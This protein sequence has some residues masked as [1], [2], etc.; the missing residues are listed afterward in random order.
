M[1]SLVEERERVVINEELSNNCV[2]WI[3][4]WRKQF[5][6]KQFCDPEPENRR[7]V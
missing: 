7:D 4:R 6:I 2:E 1:N 5:T 3:V